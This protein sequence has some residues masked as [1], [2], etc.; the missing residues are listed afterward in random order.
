MLVSES[1]MAVAVRTLLNVAG[2][3]RPE[4]WTPLYDNV[5]IRNKIIPAFL[6]ALEEIEPVRLC[7][8][9]NNDT[10]AEKMGLRPWS[11]FFEENNRG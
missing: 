4:N 1:N 5:F 6:K 9:F 3:P 8:E 10:V 7:Y 11:D 2:F